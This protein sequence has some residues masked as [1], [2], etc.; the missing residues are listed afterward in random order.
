MQLSKCT[1]AESIIIIF[2]A[3]DVTEKKAVFQ[4][5]QFEGKRISSGLLLQIEIEE[6][7]LF[8]LEQNHLILV[9]KGKMIMFLIS[10]LPLFLHFSR[11]LPNPS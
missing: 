3:L 7:F 5:L 9:F 1:P 8:K 6:F 2:L 4:E 10:G 11:F